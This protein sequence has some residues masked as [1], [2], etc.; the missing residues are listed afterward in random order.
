MSVFKGISFKRSN[1][2]EFLFFL[3]L[4]AIFAVLSKLS[5]DYTTVYTVSIKVVHVPIDKVVST[6]DPN[7]LEI[8]TTLNGFSV[9]SNQFSDFEL[10]IDFDQLEKTASETYR[11]IPEGH[12]LEIAE[13]LSGVSEVTAIRPQQVAIQVDEL[14][15]KEVSVSPNIKVAYKTGYGPKEVAILTPTSVTVVGPKAYIDTITT[16]QT[17]I[18]D[19]TDVSDNIAAQLRVDSLALPKE[20]KLSSY[21]FEYK[22]E[23][24]KFTEGSFSIPVQVVNKNASDVK[25][26]P[27][28]VDV[29]FTVSLE[30]YESIKASDFEVVC[31]FSKHTNQDDFIILDLKKYPSTV[32]SA[33]LGIKQIKY[34][35]VN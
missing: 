12:P 6:I 15:S 9:L 31:D 24:T 25:I 4:T 5:K 30:A 28:T 27:K 8:T 21:T 17:Q 23:V 35:V 18:Q 13:A 10:A 22:Q 3:L 14:A 26:F 20:I 7:T 32:K 16:I 29:Y 2:R 11:Y 34:I 1:V 19:L 33:R